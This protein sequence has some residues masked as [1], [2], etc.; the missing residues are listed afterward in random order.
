[1][2]PPQ[3]YHVIGTDGQVLVPVPVVWTCLS[4]LLQVSTSKNHVLR[5]L[6]FGVRRVHVEDSAGHHWQI[7][8]VDLRVLLPAL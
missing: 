5:N 2:D 4:H 3:Q 1:M 8:F 7:P 6:R